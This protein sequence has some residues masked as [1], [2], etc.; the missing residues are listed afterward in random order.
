M[1]RINPYPLLVFISSLG[2]GTICTL[3]STHWIFAWIGLEISTLAIIPLMASSHHPR[4]TEATFKYFIVQA[5]G[6]ATIMLAAL[7]NAQLVTEWQISS[8]FHPL[9]A[10]LAIFALAL[11]LGLAPLHLWLP[12]VLQGLDLNTGLILSTW[13]KLAPFALIVQM[14]CPHKYIL[15]FIGA[16][17]VL[18]GGWGGIN[19][20]QLRKVLAYSSVAHLGWM[21]VVSHFAPNITAFA[22]ALY[23]LINASTFLAFKALNGA[24]INSLAHSALTI[25]YLTAAIPWV[26]MSLGGIPPLSGFTPKWF[27]VNE[28]ANNEL[29]ITALIMVFST[30]LS[31][32]FYL[33]IARA[34]SL[35]ASPNNTLYMGAWQLLKK[36]FSLIKSQLIA[37]AI[38][39]LPLTPVIVAIIKW[40]LS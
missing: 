12:E 23:I 29:P 17:S 14:P 4:A 40:F 34:L 8:T 39:L 24:S 26:L 25:P 38:L 33:R 31:L 2:L 22:L 21:L 18:L 36:R 30:L 11:K 3:M 32:F 37:G 19:Q 5:A 6:A 20:T 35:I 27:I 16:L 15:V 9:P 13:Q 10:T 28:L 1:R 7:I